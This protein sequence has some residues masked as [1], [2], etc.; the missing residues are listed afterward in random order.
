MKS[1]SASPIATAQPEKTTARPAVDMVRT[2]AASASRADAELLPEAEDDEERVVDRE[3]EPDQLDEVRHVRD[4]RELVREPVDDEERPGDRARR[5]EERDRDRPRD[6]EERA[7]RMSS[8]TGT[9]IAS[10]RRRSSREDRVEVVLDR[11]LPGDER[12]GSPGRVQLG[13]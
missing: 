11:R 3:P 10:P 7:K 6:A 9:A 13:A 12:S 1:R 8:A 4:H 2:T 5:E